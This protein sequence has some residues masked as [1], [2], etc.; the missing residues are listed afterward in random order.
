M[1]DSTVTTQAALADGGNINIQAGNLVQLVNS[2]ITTSVGTGAGNGGNITI[3]PQFFIVD[4]GRIVANAFGGRGGNINITAG[5]FLV[6]PDSVIDA[7]S[8]LGVNGTVS[9]QSPVQ[10]LSGTLSPLP[11]TLLKIS[12][13]SSQ[14]GARAQGGRLSSFTV[15]G[16]DGVPAE[17]GS[18][19]PSP[20]SEA[21]A[22]KAA[23]GLAVGAPMMARNFVLDALE[24]AC[25]Q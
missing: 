5:V 24:T 14:C 19:L 13:L 21:G 23:G 10:N 9:I 3:D 8:A 22:T 18:L 15:A 11:S 25:E 12:P 16:R 20:I 6:S 1:R 7:S 17:P 4:Q 2:S